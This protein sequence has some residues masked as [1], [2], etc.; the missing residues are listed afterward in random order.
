MKRWRSHKS[1]RLKKRKLKHSIFCLDGLD[2]VKGSGMTHSF[3]A[4]E[5]RLMRKETDT[6]GETN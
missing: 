4:R 2:T 5:N 1:E 6:L 3:T